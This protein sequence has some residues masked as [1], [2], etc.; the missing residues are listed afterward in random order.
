MFFISGMLSGKALRLQGL[1]DRISYVRGR[2]QRLMVPYFTIALFYL[3]FKIFLSRFANQPYDIAGI[4]K[5]FLG[6]NPDGGLWFLYDLFL[7]QM[8]MA[9]LLRRNNIH[10]VLFLGL[11]CSL[12]IVA[13]TT[14]WY[15]VDDAIFY[16]SFVMMGVCFSVSESFN[17]YYKRWQTW[18][19]LLLLVISLTAFFLTH[20]QFCKL[21]SGMFASFFIVGV[22]KYLDGVFRDG[23]RIGVTLK[24]FGNYTM[25]VYIFHGIL[26]VVV[27]IVFWSVLHWNYYLCCLLMLI[28][29]LLAPICIS[30]KVVRP[31]PLFKKLFL[32][33]FK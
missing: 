22:S 18:T 25:E 8:V 16:F 1:N 23:G 7:I 2:F 11:L 5:I 9:L 26:M 30:N 27:R 10:L 31:I 4:W 17:S 19:L 24:T 32:G 15:W 20:S 13:L 14:H 28:V 21:F 3:P 33:D 29:G 12:L 6:E